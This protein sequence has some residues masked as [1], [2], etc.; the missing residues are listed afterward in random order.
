MRQ[1]PPQHVADCVNEFAALPHVEHTMLGGPQE[2]QVAEL[3]LH[4]TKPFALRVSGRRGTDDPGV[5]RE[6][7]AAGLPKAKRSVGGR[8]AAPPRGPLA[9]LTDIA[10][11]LGEVNSRAG[12]WTEYVF[13]AID[14]VEPDKVGTR[15]VAVLGQARAEAAE[16]R[17]TLRRLGDRLRA[18]LDRLGWVEEGSRATRV[19]DLQELGQQIDEFRDGDFDIPE[20]VFEG[21]DYF[22]LPACD[23]DDTYFEA[24]F[25]DEPDSDPAPRPPG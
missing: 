5:A 20:D 11:H 3:T 18:A 12:R 23:D 21:D 13:D 25:P 16:A 19:P 7:K 15:W 8:K 22:E 10:R 6:L 17:E 4:L 24:D 14:E 1:L 9:A 2:P